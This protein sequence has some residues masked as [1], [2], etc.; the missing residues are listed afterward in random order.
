MPNR[1]TD[2]D[3]INGRLKQIHDRLSHVANI[4]AKAAFVGGYGAGG[5][6]EPERDRLIAE[7][8][9]L[10]DRMGTIIGTTRPI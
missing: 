9:R 2:Q 1:I 3:R 10:L 4:E 8:D 5:E 7:T 6:F